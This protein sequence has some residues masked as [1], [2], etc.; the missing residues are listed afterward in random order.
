MI[1]TH[2][3]ARAV[4]WYLRSG[5]RGRT[6]LTGFA[7]R[8]LKPLWCVPI[9]I[10]GCAPVYVDLRTGHAQYLLQGEPWARAPREEAE[11]D[12]MRRVVSQGDVVLDIGANLGLHSVFLSSLIG[13]EGR[14]FVFEPNGAILRTLRRTVR[15]L[16]NASLHEYAL[17]DRVGRAALF[18]PGDDTKASLADWTDRSIDGEVREAECEQRRLDDLV[19]EGT[20]AVPDFIKCDVEGAELLVFRGGR[21]VLDCT[22]A[23]ILLFEVNR[24]TVQGFGLSAA[25][26]RD[27]L[28]SL[29]AP[30][31]HFFEVQRGGTLSPS[32]SVNRSANLLAIPEAKLSRF[33]GLGG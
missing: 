11:Q 17:S 18:V 25:A 31:Y 19:D 4:R 10:E 28:Q 24:H 20:I 2:L 27:F 21:R 5:L 32:P 33:P 26:A 22:R 23:P 30:R 9:R 13:A 7:T 14:L 8:I 3:L 15:G 1:G 6:R 29:E 16:G 12:V